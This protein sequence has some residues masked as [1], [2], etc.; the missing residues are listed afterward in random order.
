MFRCPAMF[1]ADDVVYLMRRVGVVLTEKTILTPL[2]GALRDQSPQR[3][4]DVTSQAVYTS[5]PAP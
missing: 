1:S 5:A 3:L 2:G 4:T